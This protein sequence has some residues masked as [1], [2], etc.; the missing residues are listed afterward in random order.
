MWS[1]G[2]IIAARDADMR[3]D[4][5]A[6][7]TWDTHCLCSF[8]KLWNALLKFSLG[9]QLLQV[10][11]FGGKLWFVYSMNIVG[12]LIADKTECMSAYLCDTNGQVLQGCCHDRSVLLMAC[13]VFLFTFLF[14]RVK[15]CKSFLDKYV[16]IERSE[17]RVIGEIIEAE[18]ISRA[19]CMCV[20]T[21][22]IFLCD[23]EL[24]F[25]RCWYR[26]SK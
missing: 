10:G 21:P 19:G 11:H 4:G 26:L 5:E 23:K 14:L 6:R 13:A 25:L 22:S 9:R 24:A 1:V 16:V 12:A 2:Q 20:S 7:A 8:I 15:T 3:Q 18:K 17:D